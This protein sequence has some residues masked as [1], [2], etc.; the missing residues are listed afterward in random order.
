M[1]DLLNKMKNI[2]EKIKNT[3]KSKRKIR[4]MSGGAKTFHK[5][6]RGDRERINKILKKR[7]QNFQQDQRKNRQAPAKDNISRDR[8]GNA[9]EKIVEDPADFLM[10]MM[11]NQP[12][13]ILGN[14]PQTILGNQG[15]LGN[16]LNFNL[17]N[18]YEVRG[19]EERDIDNRDR[20]KYNSKKDQLTEL[21]SGLKTIEDY[22]KIIK[23]LKDLIEDAKDFNYKSDEGRFNKLLSRY[24][25]EQLKI[26]RDRYNQNKN[27]S[28][29]KTIFF[30]LL[31]EQYSS[32]NK[33]DELEDKKALLTYYKNERNKEKQ[34]KN[35]GDINKR[36]YLSFLISD[37]EGHAFTPE[38]QLAHDIKMLEEKIKSTISDDVR[39]ISK[40]EIERKRSQLGK[41]KFKGRV[42]YN[43]DLENNDKKI[44]KLKEEYAKEKND[45]I[46][47]ALSKT[48][49]KVEIERAELLKKQQENE[50]QTPQDMIIK[51]KE[52]KDKTGDEDK[53][54]YLNELIRNE[55]KK[56]STGEKKEAGI[57]DNER[58]KALEQI[59]IEQMKA[60]DKGDAVKPLDFL[61]EKLGKNLLTAENAN[62]IDK[63]N[64]TGE[65]IT[66]SSKDVNDKLV[67]ILREIQRRSGKVISLPEEVR[68]QYSRE[69]AKE[70]MDFIKQQ[71][72]GIEDEHELIERLTE[73]N[74]EIYKVKLENEILKRQLQMKN[75]ENQ[76]IKKND[77]SK[78]AGIEIL[79][80]ELSKLESSV[81]NQIDLLNY[82]DKESGLSIDDVRNEMKGKIQEN[83]NKLQIGDKFADDDRYIL[84]QEVSDIIEEQSEFEKEEEEK[85]KKEEQKK[86]ESENMKKLK[87][88]EKKLEQ[89]G[90]AI[91]SDFS[92]KLLKMAKRYKIKNITKYNS[93]KE[94]REAIELLKIYK[95]N[96]Q[97]FKK[98]SELNV[99]AKN[100]DLDPLHYKSAKVLKEAIN[101]IIK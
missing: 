58:E 96:R 33:E 7:T 20:R 56:M 21:S 83:I 40:K 31:N 72:T 42:F 10:N 1:S 80:E 85:R 57:L 54:A 23:L 3:K 93:E 30:N 61:R 82:R 35:G 14:H 64:Q 29:N 76:I 41:L 94:L 34:Q 8:D 84:K 63:L 52:V 6:T 47:E 71:Q 101:K 12:Q 5:N 77:K 73:K 49:N 67:Q 18:L 44:A 55:E 78:L 70:A 36:H 74:N 95:K 43:E 62:L 69:A 27:S 81:D 91:E 48:I 87:E 38:E 16:P 68:E 9:R 89:R 13:T 65:N 32:L 19:N 86:E 51:L 99:V 98:R 92:D 28:R 4:E 79:K 2:S 97:L 100:I 66:K 37:L 17:K 45:A 90:G 22:T 24:I 50:P 53:I 88:I 60:V 26:A 75:Q 59:L 39:E 46:K 25:K 15:L 11:E